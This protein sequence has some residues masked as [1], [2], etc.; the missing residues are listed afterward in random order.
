MRLFVALP[1]PPKIKKNLAEV[2]DEII[3]C[4]QVKLVEENNIHLTLKFL[5]EVGEDAARKIADELNGIQE[6]DC[7][8]MTVAGL[9]VF[10]KPSFPRVLW[11]GVSEG[12]GKVEELQKKV[13]EILLSS[14]FKEDN[15]FHPHYTLARIKKIAEK[16][17]LEETLA[18]HADT[19]YGTFDAEKIILMESRLSPKGPA[20][21]PL[22]EYPLH[23]A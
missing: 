21:T 9:G 20:Y 15:R 19:V 23:E 6:N 12:S 2:Q 11:A 5:G 10:P 22:K 4:G 17:L 7:F 8:R 1:C 16:R 3:K 13:D 14:G 18:S